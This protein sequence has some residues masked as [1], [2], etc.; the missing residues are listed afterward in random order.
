MKL[1]EWSV[2]NSL[3]VN[4]LTVFILVAGGI[5]IF[6]INREAFPNIKFDIVQVTT[7][8]RGSTPSQMARRSPPSDSI[9][10]CR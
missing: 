7:K 2:K 5:S 9:P 10:P 3:F 1:A 6:T 8:Y 4:L